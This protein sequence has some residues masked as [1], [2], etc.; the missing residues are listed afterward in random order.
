[1]TVWK[2]PAGRRYVVYGAAE[3]CPGSFPSHR[4]AVAWIRR[5]YGNDNVMH[6][7]PSAPGEVDLERLD[8]DTY[9]VTGSWIGEGEEIILEIAPIRRRGELRPGE[10]GR[11]FAI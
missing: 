3:N 2:Q 4:A 8:E 10:Q 1:M 5:E 9:R 11:L 6:V 7:T